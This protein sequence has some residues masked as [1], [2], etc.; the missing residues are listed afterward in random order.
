MNSRLGQ[1]VFKLLF[2]SFFIATATGCTY[3]SNVSKQATYERIQKEAPSQRNLKFLLS[4]Q[5]HFVYGRILD[6][7]NQHAGKTIAIA[8]FSSKFEE[9]ELVDKTFSTNISTHYGLNL[10]D[11]NFDIFAFTDSDQNGQMDQSEIIGQLNLT[12]SPN[13]QSENVVSEADIKLT[14]EYSVDWEISIDVPAATSNEESLFFP[15]GTIRSLDDPLFDRSNATLGMYEPGALL[16]T[17]PT[18]F[19]ALEEE[20]YK[21]PV[22]FVHGIGGSP[23]DFA[24]IVEQLDRDRYKPWFFYYPSGA[25]LNQLSKLFYDIFLSGKTVNSSLRPTIIVAHS[26]GGLVSRSALNRIKG[27]D[28][29]NKVELFITISSPLGGHP[30][31]AKGEKHGLITLPSWRN[32]NPDSRFIEKLHA[33]P[34][35]KGI[36]YNLI[37][38]YKD[39]T[40][41]ENGK[42]NDGVVPLVN[43]L[44]PRAMA[45]ADTQLAINNTH[46]GVLEDPQAIEHI[47]NAINQVKGYL[48]ESHWKYLMMDG[49][50]VGSDEEY[51]PL[52]R[53]SLNTYGPYMN[54]LANKDIHHLNIPI[55]KQF[56]DVTDGKIKARTPSETAWLKYIA[57][58]P[59]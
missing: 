37:Y 50:D 19:H 29:E 47:I 48:P 54:A 1:L 59:N 35:P 8:A 38:T 6:E 13:Q 28:S 16:E 43:Q 57:S 33:K 24:T 39:K 49:Y 27:R 53:Y 44:E 55:L 2:G 45:Q 10:P 23:R 22:I 3:L 36:D 52:E 30:A 46:T 11:G 25:D 26:M 31:A 4:N 21:I 12:L 56:V 42:G 9:N 5:T 18:M 51:T 34:L 20:T 58:R 7:E 14:G 17:S 41:F 15:K 40:D 32:L